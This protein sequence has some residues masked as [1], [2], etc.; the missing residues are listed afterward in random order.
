MNRRMAFVTLL[1][2]FFGCAD[3]YS[4]SS[5]R[6]SIPRPTE[7]PVAP[8][9]EASK[10]EEPKVK[11]TVWLPPLEKYDKPVK[12]EKWFRP[13]VGGGGGIAVTCG[14]CGGSGQHSCSICNGTGTL[15]S[16][17]FLRDNN[18]RWIERYQPCL[19]CSGSGGKPCSSCGGRGT[20]KEEG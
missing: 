9:R 1:A 2:A 11:S 7:P 19:Q 12:K 14:A 13:N 16:P 10:A 5:S 15:S 8:G 4:E 17:T 6:R 18:G 20:L 3:R